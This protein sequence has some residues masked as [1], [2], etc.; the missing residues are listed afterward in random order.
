[1]SKS[2]TPFR[3]A[4]TRFAVVT[5][6][7]IFSLL[8]V[9]GTSAAGLS[10]FDSV[11]EFFGMQSASESAAKIESPHAAFT[12][13]NLVVYRS[14]TGATALS[15]A[16]SAA[17]LDEYTPSGT[18]VQTITLPTT[19]AGSGNRALTVAGSSTSE[20]QITASTDGQYISV[21]GYNAATATL[22]VAGTTNNGGGSDVNRVVGRVDSSG[23]VDSTTALIGTVAA[24]IYSAGNIRDAVITGSSIYTAGSNAPF[25]GYVP[26]VGANTDVTVSGSGNSRVLNVFGGDVYYTT[27]LTFNKLAG[28]PTSTATVI[29]L[30][31]A[32][33]GNAPTGASG[34]YCFDVGNVGSIDTCYIVDGA[35]LKKYS[36]SGSTLTPHGTATITGSASSFSGVTGSV[37]SGTV[38]LFISSVAKI[39][40]ITDSTGSTGTLSGTATALTLTGNP[41]TLGANARR[42]RPAR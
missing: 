8:A 10:F 19:V 11:K 32:T 42:P 38:T 15:S 21:V 9:A 23:T 13:G 37:S 5:I 12:P 1:M 18:Y 39:E 28:L 6:I 41:V 35:S 2:Q 34:F 20:G 24:P 16:A 40:T 17:F 29:Q 33:A 36:V 31:G 7:S 4:I 22:A 14:G 30:L 27:Q 25:I 3:F 26:G